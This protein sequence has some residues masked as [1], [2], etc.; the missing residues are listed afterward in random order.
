MRVW[1]TISVGKGKAVGEGA[2]RVGAKGGIAMRYN[3]PR[4]VSKVLTVLGEYFRS[5]G[6]PDSWLL[7]LAERA[8]SGLWYWSLARE[9]LE[10]FR[11]NRELTGWEAD[12]LSYADYLLANEEIV[13]MSEEYVELTE[14]T[15]EEEVPL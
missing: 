1:Y 7:L 11:Y 14:V 3:D 2:G 6:Y 9:A 10:T 13:W 4:Y 12:A 15:D 8:V 5:C